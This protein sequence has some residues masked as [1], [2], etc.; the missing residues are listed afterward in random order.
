MTPG[1]FDAFMGG[2]W[3]ALDATE[4]KALT[5]FLEVGCHSCHTGPASGPDTPALDPT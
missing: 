1:R 3:N 4:R 2:E 5:T